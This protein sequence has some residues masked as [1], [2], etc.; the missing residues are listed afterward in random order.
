MFTTDNYSVSN[1]EICDISA[2]SFNALTFTSDSSK[3]K[4]Y[5]LPSCLVT[6]RFHLTIVVCKAPL[7]SDSE[8]YIERAL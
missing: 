5:T 4:L 6:Q 8:D 1:C 3:T 2:H 7:Q